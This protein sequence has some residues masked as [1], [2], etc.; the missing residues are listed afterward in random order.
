MIDE[1]EFDYVDMTDEQLAQQA[2]NEAVESAKI[3]LQMSENYYRKFGKQS[4]TETQKA[5]VENMANGILPSNE[6]QITFGLETL[7]Q[8]RELVKQQRAELGEAF[9]PILTFEEKTDSFPV[10]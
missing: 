2:L 9:E 6:E 7:K 10:N 5:F 1:N 8:A 3:T 4:L